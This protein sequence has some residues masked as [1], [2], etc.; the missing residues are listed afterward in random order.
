MW[1]VIT[2]RLFKIYYHHSVCFVCN[3][4]CNI[5]CTQNFMNKLNKLNASFYNRNIIC[6]IKK[7]INE[8]RDNFS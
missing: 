4:S 3:D 6:V 1:L 2:A 7:K 8:K 5:Y